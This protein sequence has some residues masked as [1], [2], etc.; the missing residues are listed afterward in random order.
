MKYFK[1]LPLINQ[2]DPSGNSIIV[3]NILTRAYL[4]PS[5]QK[6][7][8]LFYT[9]NI[10]EIDTPENMSYRYYNDPYRYWILFY[11]NGIMDPYA[12]WPLTNQQFTI[13]L[14]DKYSGAAANS[15][16]IASN[17]VTSS[18]TFSY[19]T[20]TVH[21]YE[22]YI[23]TKNSIDNQGQTITIQIDKDT[24]NSISPETDTATFNDGTTVT[25]E[26]SASAIS[27]YQYED[28]LNESKRTIQIMQDTFVPQMENQ[29]KS[30]MR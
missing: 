9:Y 1:T 15:L 28:K 26:I 11:S 29:L 10:T 20:S 17:V 7:L 5:L 14:N 24:Y 3:N 6:N 25:R 22:Q 21:H 19:I 30:L 4:L 23:T 27:I 18:Q 12:E 13:Y 8:M 2:K 16:N